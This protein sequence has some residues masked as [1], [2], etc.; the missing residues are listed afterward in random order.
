MYKTLSYM[1]KYLN[2]DLFVYM[3]FGMVHANPREGMELFNSMVRQRK[4]GGLVEWN[5]VMSR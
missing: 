4:V 1:D 5:E 2:Q 3:V